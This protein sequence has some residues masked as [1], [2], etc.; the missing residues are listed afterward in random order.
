MR[1]LG[2]YCR[3]HFRINFLSQ[4]VDLYELHEDRFFIFIFFIFF[5]LVAQSFWIE[6]TFEHH[7]KKPSFT[8]GI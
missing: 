2:K 8:F 3:S 4:D 1:S 5:Q 6:A 7:V